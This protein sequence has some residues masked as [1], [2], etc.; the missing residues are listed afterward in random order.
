MIYL[1]NLH[2]IIFYVTFFYLFF[3]TFLFPRSFLGEGFSVLADETK[4]C[5][6]QDGCWIRLH[7][8]YGNFVR[9]SPNHVSVND[10]SAANEIYGPRVTF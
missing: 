7:E 5:N 9:I 3:K 1:T 4:S 8:R 6:S 10:L 2:Q